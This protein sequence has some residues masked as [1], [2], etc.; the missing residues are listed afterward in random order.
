M[1]SGFRPPCSALS[2]P[3]PTLSG[4]WSQTPGSLGLGD[5]PGLYPE[6]SFPE[7]KNI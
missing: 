1:F 3:N 7:G 5:P 6:A 2:L 4:T